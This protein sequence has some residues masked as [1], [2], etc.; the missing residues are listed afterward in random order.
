[1]PPLIGIT[2]YGRFEHDLVSSHYDSLY[3]L[4]ADYAEAVRRA[5]GIAVI[6]PPG[7]NLFPDILER[8]DGVI[9]SGGADIDPARYGG[10]V[11]HHA[12]GRLDGERDAAE[13]DGLR[14]AID[15]A[16]LPVL[17]ICRGLQALNVALGGSL[18]EHVPDIGRGD[19]HRNADGHWTSHAVSVSAGS[20][21]AEAMGA[22]EPEG[23]SGHHQAVDRLGAGLA[24]SATAA[25]GLIEALELP[26]HPWCVAVQWHP[27]ITAGRDP[28][29]QGLFDRL[30]REA[31]GT[32]ARRRN[33]D[34]AGG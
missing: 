4:P 9:F 28:A 31:A 29:Q 14:A 19:M 6:L 30:V 24:V 5:G 22:A 13:L 20:R 34:D 15:R 21:L 11:S 26:G 17:C 32:A 10:D 25:D 3:Y 7:E 23:V 2:S 12:L 18:H 1:M 8:L 27:E 33:R 16:D